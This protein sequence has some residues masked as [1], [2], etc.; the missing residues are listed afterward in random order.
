MEET[1]G[2]ANFS[3]GFNQRLHHFAPLT[4]SGKLDMA[5]VFFVTVKKEKAYTR[6]GLVRKK[7]SPCIFLWKR[8][9]GFLR[10]PTPT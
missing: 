4:V 7:K 6:Y 3:P 1:S 2:V 8:A 10:W 9:S 5:C